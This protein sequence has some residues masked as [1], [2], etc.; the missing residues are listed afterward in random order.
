MAAAIDCLSNC[1][2]RDAL[3]SSIIAEFVTKK[4]W[5]KAPDWQ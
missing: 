5:E 4:P 1:P 2:G 3:F